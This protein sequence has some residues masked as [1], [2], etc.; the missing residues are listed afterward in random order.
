MTLYHIGTNVMICSRVL[1]ITAATAG[2]IVWK[3]HNH[4]INNSSFQ[5][6]NSI[7]ATRFHNNVCTKSDKVTEKLQASFF[8]PSSFFWPHC[9]QNPAQSHKNT[10]YVVSFPAIQS[11]I[12]FLTN[13]ILLWAVPP[14]KI[15]FATI[16]TVT[17][18]YDKSS[19]QHA[20]DFLFVSFDCIKYVLTASVK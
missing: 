7:R 11:R 17:A 15:Y 14:R 12:F 10:S 20:R 18:G 1:I 19:D 5:F 13:E 4:Q 6:S 9:M 8:C 3:P 2:F 16:L